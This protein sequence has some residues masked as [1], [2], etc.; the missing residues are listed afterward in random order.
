MPNCTCRILLQRSTSSATVSPRG[1]QARSGRSAGGVVTLRSAIS[2]AGV[3]SCEEQQRVDGERPTMLGRWCS[4]GSASWLRGRCRSCRSRTAVPTR[5]YADLLFAA[6]GDQA[7]DRVAW[8]SRHQTAPCCARSWSAN[9]CA[10]PVWSGQR[11]AVSATPGLF[12]GFLRVG[13]TAG[14]VPSHRAGLLRV[15]SGLPSAWA[16][17][18]QKGSRLKPNCHTACV[19]LACGRTRL[20][21][22]P[23]V[24]LRARTANRA[25]EV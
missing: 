22:M 11:K 24:G 7:R 21:Y 6:V 23:D 18:G 20:F 16:K 14:A 15:R 2:F 17:R 5:R 10:A 13:P 25:G 8:V 4:A 12:I 19:N 3:G 9:L 1:S